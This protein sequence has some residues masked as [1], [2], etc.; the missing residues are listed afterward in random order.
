LPAPVRTWLENA[1]GH[2]IA[3]VFLYAAPTALLAFLLCVFIEEAPLQT[4][5]APAQ[6]AEKQA[7]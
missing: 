2:G 7:A 5:V 1:Y 3:D 4:T 6:S